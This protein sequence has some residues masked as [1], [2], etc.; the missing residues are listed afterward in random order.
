MPPSPSR[1]RL[2]I[3]S[4]VEQDQALLSRG[5]QCPGQPPPP[6]PRPRPLHTAPPPPASGLSTICWKEEGR[7]E[8]ETEG[9]ARATGQGRDLCGN[10]EASEDA[11]AGSPPTAP[12]GPPS[13]GS[14]PTDHTTGPLGS[15]GMWAPWETDQGCRTP[16]AT[17]C[18]RSPLGSRRQHPQSSA[19]GLRADLQPGLWL[20]ELCPSSQGLH[21]AQGRPGSQPAPSKCPRPPAS[22]D[23]VWSLLPGGGQRAVGGLRPG[24]GGLYSRPGV[25][26]PPGP[27]GR[28]AASRRPGLRSRACRAGGRLL[29]RPEPQEPQSRWP[30]P[31]PAASFLSPLFS[32]PST[33]KG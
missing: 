4:S 7:R 14:Q 10:Q 17:R 33:V 20:P 2:R 5:P 24:L 30:G 1:W 6:T 13:P 26:S 25:T 27:A 16:M 12:P 11:G 15:L 19:G 23:R 18:P 8:G 22:R 3:V 31:F 28:E 32:A 21:G 29:A 9:E